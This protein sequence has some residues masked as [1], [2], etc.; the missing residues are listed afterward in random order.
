MYYTIEE[1][2]NGK[3]SRP[4]WAPLL[5]GE[6]KARKYWVR[7]KNKKNLRLTR[8]YQYGEYRER[9]EVC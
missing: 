2:I 5:I 3:W 8:I 6:D 9:Q 4:I 7:I 1:Y